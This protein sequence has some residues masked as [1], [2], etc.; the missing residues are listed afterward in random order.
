MS[1]TSYLPRAFS[2]LIDPKQ[3]TQALERIFVF[4]AAVEAPIAL[5]TYKN[6]ANLAL[7]TL[8]GSERVIVAAKSSAAA[9]RQLVVKSHRSR[10]FVVSTSS[11]GRSTGEKVTIYNVEKKSTTELPDSSAFVSGLVAL[12][13]SGSVSGASHA[14]MITEQDISILSCA[15]M[16]CS[17]EETPKNTFLFRL[18]FSLPEKLGGTS[19]ISKFSLFLVF[20][21]PSNLY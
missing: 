13:V 14:L 11:D 3:K 8:D 6:T 16:C 19:R 12:P 21:G 20:L 1:T 10:T 7:N 17:C 15:G 2:G 9:R 18:F 4:P 5:A